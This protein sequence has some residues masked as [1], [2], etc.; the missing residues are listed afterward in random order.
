MIITELKERIEESKRVL[1]QLNLFTR[2][3]D[4]DMM[5]QKLSEE[6]EAAE[7]LYSA[8]CRS[9]DAGSELL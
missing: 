9:V 1:V 3:P 7:Q 5:S 4:A 8:L 2:L 6:L